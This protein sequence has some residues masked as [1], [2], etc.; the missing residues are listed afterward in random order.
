MGLTTDPETGQERVVVRIDPRYFRASEVETL[1]GDASKAKE[2]LGWQ[3]EISFEDMVEE[4]MRE[5]VRRA[6]QEATLGRE[7][8]R[9]GNYF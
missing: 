3:P 5:D 7:G 6:A 1:L 9:N 8:M 4:M 2:I